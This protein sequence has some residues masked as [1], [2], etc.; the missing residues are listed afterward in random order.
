MSIR[1]SKTYWQIAK[2][3]TTAQLQRDTYD[4]AYI[5]DEDLFNV[6]IGRRG[7]DFFLGYYS[8]K[9]LGL[10]IDKYGLRELLHKKGFP[11]VRYDL[12]TSDPYVHK[13]T[14]LNRDRMLAEVVLK[15]EPIVLKMP[16]ETP[17]NDKRFTALSIEWLCLQNPD[18]TFTA[19]RP[20]LPGQ[21]FPGLGMASKSVELLM[22]AAWRLHLAGLLN[23]PQHYH[24]AFLYS[25]IFFYIDPVH[26]AM[27]TA[28]ARDT[29][30]YP[31][32]QVAWALEWQA[33]MDEVSGE[34]FTWFAAKQVVPL[35][36]ELKKVFN[37][38][39]YRRHVQR[40]SKEFKFRLDEKKYETM[41]RI[42]EVK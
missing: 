38:W 3:L 2:R 7:H 23:T 21:Q 20:Q 12:D 14:L 1:I 26:Q 24:N 22:I 4:G 42:K 19:Q 13:L 41:K 39:D 17:V 6:N 8:K 40:L 30:K 36:S 35:N 37:S 15:R 11:D 27:L 29:R 10:I 31:L 9:G 5:R 28:L 32:H 34:P 18:A 33:L 16:Y 25:K